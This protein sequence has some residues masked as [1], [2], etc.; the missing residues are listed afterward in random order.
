[1]HVRSAVWLLWLCQCALLAR[2]RTSSL[3]T[4]IGRHARSLAYPDGSGMGIFFAIGVPVDL[5]DKSVSLSFYF[6]ANYQTPHI[7][8]SGQMNASEHRIRRRAL[9]RRM[10]YDAIERQFDSYGYR[11]RACLQ[12]TICESAA[13]P[14]ERSGLVG[15]LVRII[16]TPS[17]SLAE[18]L[19]A[20]VERAEFADDCRGFQRD[21]PI[22]LLDLISHAH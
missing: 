3:K 11:G 20:D 10:L 8:N 2:G 6:E 16:F 13:F 4:A 18:N 7:N 1:M 14:F 22:S 17:S 15:D 9:D 12:R 5:P 21:C 19:E